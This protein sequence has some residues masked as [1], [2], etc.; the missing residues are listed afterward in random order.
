M[1]LG[2]YNVDTIRQHQTG[3]AIIPNKL[4]LTYITIINT[5]KG[6]FKIVQVPCFDTEYITAKNNEYT[7]KSSSRVIQMF[8]QVWLPR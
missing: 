7:D 2:A 5:T 8:N 3:A 1:G 6:W 4:S